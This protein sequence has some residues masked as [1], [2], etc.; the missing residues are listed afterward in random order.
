MAV[1]RLND[2]GYL[3]E[4]KNARSFIEA[5]SGASPSQ[6]FPGLKN[7]THHGLLSLWISKEE[8]LAL[9][10]PFQFALVGKFSGRRPSLDAIRKFFFDLKLFG[11][12][13]VTLLNSKHVLIKLNNDLDNS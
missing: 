6:I 13:S 5:L 7:T 8:I 10:A 4:T 9:V 11:E 1:N 2:P 12:F 3:N